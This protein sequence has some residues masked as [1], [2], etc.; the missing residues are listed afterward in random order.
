MMMMMM[1]ESDR[2]HWMREIFHHWMA[3]ENDLHHL[4]PT[5][6]G[7]SPLDGWVTQIF[8]IFIHCLMEQDIIVPIL[9]SKRIK[10]FPCQKMGGAL[11]YPTTCQQEQERKKA[12]MLFKTIKPNK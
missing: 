1:S 11:W 7:T 10:D 3:I 8:F 4:M 12:S 5:Q 6:R 9:S 2:H